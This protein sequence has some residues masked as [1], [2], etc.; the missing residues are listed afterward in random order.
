[1]AMA[2]WNSVYETGNAAVDTQHK[3]L[4]EMV[5][6]LHEGIVKGSAREIMAP[7]LKR[8][9]K[10]TVEHFQTEEGLMTARGYPALSR[11]KMRH[12]EL[13]RQVTDLIQQFDS[14]KLVLPLTLSRFLSDWITHHI[15]EEDKAMI[16]WLRA[17]A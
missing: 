11:H 9:A 8:L 6:E 14:G 2:E 10:Y 12:D 16:D 4:F 7:M 1:M 3:K 15:K 17:R 5:N 13:V